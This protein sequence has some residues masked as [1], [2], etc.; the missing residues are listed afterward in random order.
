MSAPN[1]PNKPPE[2][3]I[4]YNRP[5]TDYTNSNRSKRKFNLG[6]QQQP[7]QAPQPTTYSEPE[8]DGFFKATLKQALD[9]A[10]KNVVDPAIRGFLWNSL[11]SIGGSLIWGKDSQRLYSP[12]R[13]P[14]R[15]ISTGVTSVVPVDRPALPSGSRAM[16][17]EA[18]L[19]QEYMRCSKPTQE[20]ACAV[21]NKLF[22]TL[23]QNG[24]VTLANY[25]EA[26]GE[27]YDFNDE[28]FGWTALPP[29]AVYAQRFHD[30]YH[31]RMPK[32]EVL[33]SEIRR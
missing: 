16:T 11:T 25:Y 17:E 6:G 33:D 21:M 14:Y 31:V 32:L 2:Q 27:R 22:R 10:I 12:G 26:F 24:K 19:N 28:A 5:P 4:A 20:A 18:R 8:R 7:V 29:D 1:Q 30:G 3:L 13:I 15:E 9:D 23:R